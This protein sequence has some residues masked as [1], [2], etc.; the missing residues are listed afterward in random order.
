VILFTPKI[1]GWEIMFF[2]IQCVWEPG[3]LSG[4]RFIPLAA[5]LPDTCWAESVVFMLVFACVL[6]YVNMKTFLIRYK[7]IT[8][9]VEL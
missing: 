9:F 6:K 2:D 3:I 1:H 4:F 8:L 7:M 5:S